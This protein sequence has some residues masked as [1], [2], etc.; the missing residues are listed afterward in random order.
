MEERSSQKYTSIICG[1]ASGSVVISTTLLHIIV[2]VYKHYTEA[3]VVTLGTFLAAHMI[4]AMWLLLYYFQQ[5]FWARVKFV[6]LVPMCCHI[7]STFLA[8]VMAYIEHDYEIL[9][10]VLGVFSWISLFVVFFTITFGLNHILP[11]SSNSEP[12]IVQV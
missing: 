6:C 3:T 11:Y 2:A 8:S 12:I 7:L 10:L 4:V 5:S 1:T 9:V